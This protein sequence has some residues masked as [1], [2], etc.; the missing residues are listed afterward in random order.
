MNVN[1]YTEKAQEAVLA[2][3]QLASRQQHAEMTPEHLLVALIQQ[4][5]GIVPAVLGKMTVDT[6]YEYQG[7]KDVDG[8]TCAVIQPTVTMKLEGEAKLPMTVK[9][10]SS[11]G[12][13]L[14]NEDQGRLQSSL[15]KQNM[16][17]EVTVGSNQ[18]VQQTIHQTMSLKVTP[19]K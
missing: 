17:I 12:E 6:T 2:A 10:Q 1:K 7:T 16:T 13:I 19:V 18:S 3:Q 5:D 14:F 15:V 11:S 9:D 8:A 4:R